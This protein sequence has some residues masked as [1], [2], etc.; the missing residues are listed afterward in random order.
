MVRNTIR[1]ALVLAAAAV[2]LSSC[3]HRYANPI[4]KQ[5]DQPDK[6][7]F[8]KA[9]DDLSHN[10][11]SIS[12]MTL[13]TLINAYPDS[14]YLAKAKLALADGWFQEGDAHAMAQA[15]AEYK[16]FILFYPAMEEAAEAQAKVCDIHYGHMEKGDRDPM[17]AMRAEAECRTLLTQYP[18][19]KAA[20]EV[21]QKLRNIQENLAVGEYKV[22]KFYQNKGS[23]FPAANRYQ[24][25][26]DNYPLFSQADEAVWLAAQNYQRLGDKYERQEIAQLTK[27]VHEYPLSI[28]TEEAKA[29]L[30]ELKAP[31]PEADPVAYDRMKYE[32][33]NRGKIGVFSKFFGAFSMHPNLSLA[34]KSGA[35]QM[36]G[37]RPSIPANVP[38]RAAGLLGTSGDITVSVATDASALDTN[39]DARTTPPAAA[40]TETTSAQGGAAAPAAAQIDAAQKPPMKTASKSQPKPKKPAKTPKPKTPKK[41]AKQPPPKP[42]PATDSS[43]PPKP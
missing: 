32:L 10:R 28:H 38:P 27:V 30:Q 20:P 24:T 34:A 19:S 12:R 42:A 25:L 41:S 15:E 8:D 18:N 14:E 36:Q 17:E 21:E 16:D 4:A 1:N 6:V 13:T 23:F 11:F 2:L 3:A 29:R 33:A 35:P 31:V 22:G 37:M 7:L 5:T 26:A 9:I 43:A 40:G 39:P